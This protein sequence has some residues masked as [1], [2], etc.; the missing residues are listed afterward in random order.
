MKENDEDTS[1]EDILSLLEEE[2]K[3]RER[4][5]AELEALGEKFEEPWNNYLAADQDEPIPN[6]LAMIPDILSHLNGLEVIEHTN[7]EEENKDW[8]DGDHLLE[9][10][11]PDGGESLEI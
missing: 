10:R 1:L 11:N 8:D 9:V 7:A 2:D 3:E 6:L 4:E 5:K